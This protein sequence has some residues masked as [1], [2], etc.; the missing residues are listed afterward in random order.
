MPK[1]KAPFTFQAIKIN[2]INNHANVSNVTGSCKSPNP[3]IVSSFGITIPD[4]FKPKKAINNPIPEVI[5]NFKEEGIAP[6]NVSLNFV[7]LNKTKIIPAER[8]STRL[9]SSHVA[10][11]YAVFCLKKKNGPSREEVDA[12]AEI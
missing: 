7:K 3:T 2:V 6:I 1:N 9:N 10:I 8:K 11:A 4:I 5:P 12:P